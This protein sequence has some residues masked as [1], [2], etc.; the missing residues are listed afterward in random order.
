MGSSE[1]RFAVCTR[2]FDDDD[3]ADGGDGGDDDDATTTK[4]M[5]E[6]IHCNF[7]SLLTYIL[8]SQW[9]CGLNDFL[10]S[11]CCCNS[12]AGDAVLCSCVKEDDDDEYVHIEYS[13]MSYI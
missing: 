1:T 7:F 6:I 2:Q 10:S 5:L 12:V 3:G 11:Y 8:S 9:I 13:D 4:A